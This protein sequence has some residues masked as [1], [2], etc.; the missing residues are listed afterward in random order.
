M[1][2]VDVKNELSNSKIIKSKLDGNLHTN[3]QYGVN[4]IPL[5]DEKSLFDENIGYNKN[6]KLNNLFNNNHYS[7]EIN[8]KNLS[9]NK[10]NN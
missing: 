7:Y 8:K 9:K 4:F 2:K 5:I 6:N 3:Y 10:I 1:K